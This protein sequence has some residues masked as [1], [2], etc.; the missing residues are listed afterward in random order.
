MYAELLFNVLKLLIRVC[1]L[2][3][4]EAGVETLCCFFL[5][6]MMVLNVAERM[7]AVGMMLQVNN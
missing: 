5:F 2:A 4:V 1:A 3:V 6:S 7:L